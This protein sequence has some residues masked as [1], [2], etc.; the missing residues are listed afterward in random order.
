MRAVNHHV[1]TRDHGPAEQSRGCPGGAGNHRTKARHWHLAGTR[2]S[3]AW[4]RGGAETSAFHLKTAPRYAANRPPGTVPGFTCRTQPS[5]GPLDMASTPK[6]G[7]AAASAIGAVALTRFYGSK[8]QD[9]PLSDA[10]MRTPSTVR[11]TVPCAA[12]GHGSLAKNT[13]CVTGHLA[14]FL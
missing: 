7:S 12:G 14:T 4:H 11:A 2:R 5:C 8:G 13:A 3:D 9:G 6:P 10:Q 1:A